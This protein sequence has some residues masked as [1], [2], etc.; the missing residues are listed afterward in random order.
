MIEQ[1]GKGADHNDG[2]RDGY[3]KNKGVFRAKG[4]AERGGIGQWAKDHG[5]TD[6]RNFIELEHCLLREIEQLQSEGGLE[7]QDTQQPLK[8]QPPTN[9]AQGNASTISGKGPGK[10]QQEAHP[11][12]TSQDVCHGK[13]SKWEPKGSKIKSRIDR[14]CPS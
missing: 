1:G 8:P 11:Q 9:G 10:E 12:E 14:C 2:G 5:R 3:R 7:N 6:L 4:A 13:G